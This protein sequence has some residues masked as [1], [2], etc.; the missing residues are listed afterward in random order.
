[1]GR[2]SIKGVLI[3]G[4]VDTFASALIGVFAAIIVASVSHLTHVPREVFHRHGI[5]DLVLIL[6]GLASSALGGFVAARL[7][8]HDE[9]LNGGLSSSLCLLISL[10]FMARG[11]DHHPAVVQLLSLLAAPAFAVFGGY[12]RLRQKGNPICA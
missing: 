1:M 3:G 11:I 5:L 4:V 8:N 10:F 6:N 9:L 12:L 2:I 7:A